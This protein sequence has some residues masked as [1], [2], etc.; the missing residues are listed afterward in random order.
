[1]SAL[2]EQHERWTEARSRLWPVTSRK[3]LPV[4]RPPPTPKPRPK[5]PFTLEHPWQ[6]LFL[7]PI[8]EVDEYGNIVIEGMFMADWKRIT[9]EVCEKYGV[10][11]NEIISPRR[12]RAI[13]HARHEAFW[14]CK[15]ETT[16]SFPAIGRRFGGRDHT[17]VLHGVKKHE[18]RMREAMN[19]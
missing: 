14:R 15:N 6:R 17:T 9:L 3:K 19:G 13:C 11:F 1:M 2:A 7:R 5:S 16:M 8:E 4:L 12:D 10:R 18:Q